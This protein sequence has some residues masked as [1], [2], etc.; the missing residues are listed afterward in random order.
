MIAAKEDAIGE[1]HQ[2]VKDMGLEENPLIYFVSDNG[3]AT[4]TEATENGPLKGGK[5]TTFEGGINVP[6]MMKWKGQ[7]EPGT[8]Y[9]EPVT[10]LDVFSTS[11][12]AINCPLPSDRVYDGVDLLPFIKGEV[13]GKPHEALYW[14]SAHVKAMR[15]GDWKFMMSDRDNWI[16]LYNLKND[17][18]EAVDLNEQH[19]DKYYEMLQAHKRWQKSLPSKPLWPRIMDH[20]FT[21]DGKTYYFP[22]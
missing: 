20:R 2:A 9:D 21:I 12:A 18:W 22:T 16:H 11:A 7:I 1:I 8:V 13:K 17:K 19:P 14:A 4:Y 3:G 15:Q 6:F 5:F 10:A